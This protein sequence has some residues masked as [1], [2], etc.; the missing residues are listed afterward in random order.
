[1]KRRLTPTK[2]GVDVVHRPHKKLDLRN[3]SYSAQYTCKKFEF[4]F[5]HE[6][7]NIT[8]HSTDSVASVRH[9]H[10]DVKELLMEALHALHEKNTPDYAIIHFYLHC[11]GMDSDFMFSGSGSARRTLKKLLHGE[12]LDIIID[13][14]A[15]MIQSGRNVTLDNET[16]LTI[17]AFIP[18]M[19]YR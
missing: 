6:K 11:S 19:E 17:Y 12:D 15:Q 18:P 5:R 8:T 2:E 9:K 7:E 1:M 4:G 14:F 13:R 10:E 3:Y 16:R